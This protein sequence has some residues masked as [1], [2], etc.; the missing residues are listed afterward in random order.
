MPRTISPDP[1]WRRS[2][3]AARE[4]GDWHD[5]AHELIAL[6]WRQGFGPVATARMLDWYTSCH[7]EVIRA[8]AKE[9]AQ[10][11]HGA[12]VMQAVQERG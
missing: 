10:E 7:P 2:V 3:D 4:N 11:G 12:Q 5:S 6:L 1:K 9:L 8:T